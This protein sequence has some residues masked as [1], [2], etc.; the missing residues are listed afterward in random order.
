[1]NEPE[2]GILRF[3]R[4]SWLKRLETSPG[5]RRVDRRLALLPTEEERGSCEGKFGDGREEVDC[6]TMEE[7]RARPEPDPSEGSP[8]RNGTSDQLAEGTVGLGFLL[9]GG[10]QTQGLTQ[11]SHIDHP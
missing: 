6:E 7:E 11:I 5:A 10:E 4:L 8:K 9:K 3:L 1:V 2:P